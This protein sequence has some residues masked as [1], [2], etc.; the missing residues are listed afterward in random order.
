M[1]SLKL[2]LFQFEYIFMI[3]KMLRFQQHFQKM[4]LVAKF[5]LGINENVHLS[6]NMIF[7]RNYKFECYH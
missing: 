1:L 5:Q 4:S 2:K 7:L 6:P 3:V